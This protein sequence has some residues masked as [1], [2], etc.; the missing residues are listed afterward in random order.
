MGEL[1]QLAAFRNCISGAAVPWLDFS[2]PDSAVDVRPFQRG[3][4]VVS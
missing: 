2:C 3:R 4:S 1:I